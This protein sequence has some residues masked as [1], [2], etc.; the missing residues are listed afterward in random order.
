MTWLVAVSWA[1]L[2][3]LL[4]GCPQ[5]LLG[6]MLSTRESARGTDFSDNGRLGFQEQRYRRPLRESGP[7]LDI[8]VPSIFNDINQDWRL[9]HFVS[10]V[11]YEW[12]VTL[13]VR[14]IQDLRTRVL[15]RIGSAHFYATVVSQGLLCPEHRF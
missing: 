13:L 1:A 5:A 3:R 4:C 2:R 7:T 11:W 9:W 14:W 6:G 8:P 15:L 10:W 12:E